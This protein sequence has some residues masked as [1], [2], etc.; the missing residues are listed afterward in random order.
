MTSPPPSAE[1]RRHPQTIGG[2]IYLGVLAMTLVGLV[3]IIAGPWRGGL[4]WMGAAVLVAGA[5]RL[6]L[7]EHGAGMLRVRRRWSDVLTLTLVGVALLTLATYVPSQ[8]G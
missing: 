4:R 5:S 7:S 1:R 8:P 6:V 3:I 2:V